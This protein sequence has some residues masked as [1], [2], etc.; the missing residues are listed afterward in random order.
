MSEQKRPSLDE[1]RAAALTGAARGNYDCDHPGFNY[2]MGC[3]VKIRG[4]DMLD[5]LRAAGWDLTQTTRTIDFENTGC[6]G[7]VSRDI[8]S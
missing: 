3:V 4:E 7:G 8:C 2:C 6:D 1:E 5:D